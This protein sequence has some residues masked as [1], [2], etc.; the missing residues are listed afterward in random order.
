[1]NWW[2]RS[3]NSLRFQDCLLV[4]LLRS[5]MGLTEEAIAYLHN[6]LELYIEG[7]K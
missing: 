5:G 1:M 4:R 7:V 3:I 2:W 6:S